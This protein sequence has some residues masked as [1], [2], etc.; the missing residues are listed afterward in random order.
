MHMIMKTNID[1]VLE[2]EKREFTLITKA[3]CGKLREEEVEEARLLGEQIQA[4]FTEELHRK[5]AAAEH[6]LA[7]AIKR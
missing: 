3:L 6:A 5:H 1:V 2:L 4:L 7:Q